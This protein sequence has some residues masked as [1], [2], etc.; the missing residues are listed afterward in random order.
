[1]P[2]LWHRVLPAYGKEFLSDYHGTNP[3]E[4]ERRSDIAAQSE[5]EHAASSFQ[6]SNTAQDSIN[7][8]YKQALRLTFKQT[9]MD[10]L[11][12]YYIRQGG[13]RCLG[14]I[15]G[16]VYVGS[17]LVQRGSGIG[18]FLSSLFRIVKPC[19]SRC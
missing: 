19:W 1:M 8:I 15:N 9:D 17:H 14:D 6:E 18:S 12:A 5:T 7:N 11:T 16:P 3:D 4:M 2:Q 10:P 13:G